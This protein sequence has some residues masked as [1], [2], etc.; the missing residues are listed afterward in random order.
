[1]SF[2]MWPVYYWKDQGMV[3]PATTEHVHTVKCT[4]GSS[5][6]ESFT[7]LAAHSNLYELWCWDINIFSDHFCLYSCNETAMSAWRRWGLPARNTEV[8]L[9]QVMLLT[10]KR[11]RFHVCA[12]CCPAN[13]V[14][15]WDFLWIAPLLHPSA[16]SRLFLGWGT[17]C[18]NQ[19]SQS[20]E[21]PWRKCPCYPVLRLELIFWKHG[22]VII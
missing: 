22:P 18:T 20:D 1:M 17:E 4:G 16:R 8:V 7:T 5:V 6:S 19:L 12:L 21:L 15:V 14:R 11:F 3:V 10:L 13:V 2:C 9:L